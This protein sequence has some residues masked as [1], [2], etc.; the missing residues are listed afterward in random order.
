MSKHS[1]GA[2]PRGSAGTV[3]LAH[4]FGGVGK[5]ALETL[6]DGYTGQHPDS[7]VQL[8]QKDNVK[9]EVKCDFMREDP[10][11]AWINWP[12]ENLRP[13]H[14]AK[15]LEPLDDVWESTG[16]DA[17]C[18]QA[19][20][21][22]CRIDGTAYAVPLNVQ[23][24]NN[25][26]Y[27]RSVLDSAGVD[28]RAVTTPAQFVQALETVE[29]ETDA[30]GIA[31]PQRNPWVTLQLWETVL[32]GT[33][34]VRTF[35]QIKDGDAADHARA[36]STALEIVEQC[37]TYSPE[38]AVY[39]SSGG[40][41][42]Q[43]VDGDA[44]FVYAGDWAVGDF[45]GAE[46]FE[47]GEH[48]GHAPFPGTDDVYARA[49]DAFLVPRKAATDARQSFLEYICSGDAMARFCAE[50]GAIPPRLD[51][52]MDRFEP[53]FTDQQRDFERCSHSPLTVVGPGVSSAA[54]IDLKMAFVDFLTT[55]DI[56]AT[57]DQ[58]VAAFDGNAEPVA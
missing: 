2:T 54:F 56:E 13:Y 28:P 40:A 43:V 49:G 23:R 57:T 26:F 30:C 29:A 7:S 42:Q 6:I 48:W 52:P 47:Q 16:L 4:R 36:I 19:V 25:V 12:A 31:L 10:P 3:A 58:L 41:N 39:L 27:N 50:R 37:Q 32:M 22:D 45:Q 44:G 9:L 14:T 51:A 21:E 53:F 15:V 1:A 18:Q 35:E 24:T 33:D 8:I 46:E 34:G 11:D 17:N 20:R 5:R 38:G 55:G